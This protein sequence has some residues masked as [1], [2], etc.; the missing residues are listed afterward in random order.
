MKRTIFI[1]SLLF[2]LPLAAQQTYHAQVVD[3]ETGEALPYAQV[4]VSAGNGVLTDGEG[5]FTL[6]AKKTGVVRISYVGYDAVQ[7]KTAAMGDRIQLHPLSAT[8]QEVTIVPAEE[9]LE[10]MLRRI[11]KEFLREE[12]KRSNYFYRLTNT[13]AGTQELV[14]AYLNAYSMGNLRDVVFT[15]GRRLKHAQYTIRRSGISF[16]N[17]QKIIETGPVMRDAAAWENIG[18]PFNPV[19]NITDTATGEK[20]GNSNLDKVHYTFSGQLLE[21]ADGK[22]IYKITMRGNMEKSFIDG[23]V[24]VD[25]KRY[26]LLSFEGELHNF[27]LEVG[28]D[29]RHESAVVQP[30]I[31][32]TYTHRHGFTEVE[33]LVTTMDVGDLQCRSVLMSLNEYKLPFGKKKFRQTNNLVE[34]IDQTSPDT[35]LWRTANIQRMKAEEQLVLQQGMKRSDLR[36]WEYAMRD[37]THDNTGSLQPYIERLTAFGRTIPQ[38]KVYVHMDNTCYFQGDTIWFTAYTRQTTDD[39]PSRVS[40]VLYVELLNQDGYLVERKL[41]RFSTAASTNSGPTRAGS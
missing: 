41:I 31:R 20:W 17:L 27:K 28:K 39:L 32:I 11:D 23:V 34:A 16:S 8:M 25:A 2:C 4:Y 5:W 21:T 12:N 14:E 18:K 1:I 7:V 9:V 36:D 33:S 22:G 6:E 19:L 29:L 24:Y 13:Y 35:A 30:H 40:G 10:K 26:Q 37:D 3:G 15:A 38:E